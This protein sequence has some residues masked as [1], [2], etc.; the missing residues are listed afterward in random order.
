MSY[1]VITGASSGIGKEFAKRFAKRDFDLLLVAT[2]G[3]K[4]LK[5]K[6][7]INEDF[8]VNILTLISD[9][10]KNDGAKAV[11]DY[12][13]SNNL[14]VS[15]FVNNAGFG[16]FGLF[17][18]GDVEKFQKMI[19]LN[20]KGLMTLAYYFGNY[21]KE[22][23]FGH[24]V[25]IASIAGFMPGPYMTV[26][27]ASKAFVLNFSLALREELKPY[28][29]KVTTICPGPIDT[30]FWNRANVTMSNVKKKYFTRNVKQLADSGMR[31]VDAGGG[32]CVDGILYKSAAVA[33]RF[34]PKQTLTSIVKFVNLKLG[35]K[36]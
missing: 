23:E 15:C 26:Y 35:N 11:Y 14:N 9:L 5:A 28:N 7:E 18:D 27:Y 1:V 17:L 21:F 3:E 25:N 10:S 4:L 2:N 19:D 32:L 29:V 12:V 34:V 16:D 20:D 24:I 33:T 6:E 22:K 30:N 8:N 36:E 13:I 31:K